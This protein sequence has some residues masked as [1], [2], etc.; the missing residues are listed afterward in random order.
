MTR[1]DTLP[2]TPLGFMSR[3]NDHTYFNR[4][5]THL[6]PRLLSLDHVLYLSPQYCKLKAEKTRASPISLKSGSGRRTRKDQV[7]RGI[8]E[9]IGLLSRKWLA[10]F[11]R[12]RNC[13][14]I[15]IIIIDKK[16]LYRNY[17]IRGKN[18]VHAF[19]YNT[20]NS[21]PIWMKSEVYSE[22][23]VGG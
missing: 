1:P 5:V 17:S 7:W 22:Y 9:L 19:G 8:R 15:I 16:G 13:P 23:I 2:T 20:A 12:V 3:E 6:S 10:M 14:F 4:L 11:R 18:G 21:K